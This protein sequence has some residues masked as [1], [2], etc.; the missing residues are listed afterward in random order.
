MK[1]FFH[2][3]HEASEIDEIQKIHE[4]TLLELINDLF[5][6]NVFVSRCTVWV[7][8]SSLFFQV[9]NLISRLLSLCVQIQSEEANVE[10]LMKDY[11]QVASVFK[12][13]LQLDRKNAFSFNE[14]LSRI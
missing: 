9:A 12:Q 13:T 4:T 6:K 14:L 8:L 1:G 5:I 7:S 11:H 3:I 2:F 10:K